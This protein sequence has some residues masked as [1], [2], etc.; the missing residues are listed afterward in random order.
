MKRIVVTGA[1]GF[2]G[3]NL[4]EKLLEQGHQVIG[5]D[6][7]L[8][9]NES[10]ILNEDNYS[11]YEA[12][13]VKD[14]LSMLLQ[15]HNKRGIHYIYNLACPASP[16]HYKTHAFQ[17][18]E[19][20]YNGT[21]NMIQYALEQGN[22][23]MLHTSTSEVYGDPETDDQKE[24]YWGN[25]NSFGP[26]ACYD[27]G[28]RVAEALIY[29]AINKLKSNIGIARIFNTY[30]PYMAINDGRVISNFITQGLQGNHLIMYGSGFQS[31]SFCYVDD[32]IEGLIRICE[33]DYKEIFNVGNPDRHAIVE[34]A[35]VIAE[36]TDA[37]G[38][39]ND[40]PSP[41]DPMHRK[42]NID[43]IQHYLGWTPKI[44]LN[45]GLDDTI[46]YFKYAL[47]RQN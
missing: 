39:K 46:E 8:T 41:D 14:D 3:R 31:R 47:E 20:C 9:G 42:P 5:V 35:E 27:E 10:N 28:K 6:N 19:V 38:W 25:V 33:S 24:T 37:P 26:R 13:I 11:F 40:A 4:C 29:E 45:Q 12:D 43:K 16:D 44:K 21:K 23:R 1:T 32:T 30:G 34:I 2:L 36:K 18:L 22:V 7:H 17:T 15:E